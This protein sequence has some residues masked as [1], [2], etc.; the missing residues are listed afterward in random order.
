[1]NDLLLVAGEVGK[2]VE[3]LVNIMT[4][5]EQE[6]ELERETPKPILNSS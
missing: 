2:A 6:E 1:M 3:S 4:D 5:D